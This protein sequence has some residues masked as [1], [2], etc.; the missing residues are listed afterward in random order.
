MKIVNKLLMKSSVLSRLQDVKEEGS[1]K[2][3]IMKDFVLARQ[4]FVRTQYYCY[5][6]H[7]VYIDTDKKLR[8]S[9]SSW[10]HFQVSYLYMADI[11]S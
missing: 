11:K 6:L 1:I 5:Y 10:I 8:K 2:W 7:Q 3:Q 4:A 9:F